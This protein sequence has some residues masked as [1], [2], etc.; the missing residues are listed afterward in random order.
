MGGTAYCTPALQAPAQLA[1]FASSRA[2][3]LNPPPGQKVMARILS[4]SVDPAVGTAR[5]NA[6]GFE[7]AEALVLGEAGAR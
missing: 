4:V 3:Q 5:A 6:Q 2:L 1:A 7:R